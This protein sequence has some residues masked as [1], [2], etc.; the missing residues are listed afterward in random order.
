V[1]P[2]TPILYEIYSLYHAFPP[3]VG[4][5]KTEHSEISDLHIPGDKS[6]IVHQWLFSSDAFFSSGREGLIQTIQ[7]NNCD[8]SKKSIALDIRGKENE[9]TPRET[10]EVS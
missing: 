6:L 2:A 7:T 3:S 8:A 5:R 1:Y 10:V 4:L 9:N